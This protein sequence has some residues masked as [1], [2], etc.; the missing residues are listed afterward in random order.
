[1]KKLCCL[2]AVFMIFSLLSACG[3][4]RY[5]IYNEADKWYISFS[6]ASYRP[7]SVTGAQVDSAAE[8]KR[9]LLRKTLPE[10]I[11]V[12]LKLQCGSDRLEICDPN[13]MG[14][15]TLPEGLSYEYVTWDGKR[16]VFTIEDGNFSGKITSGDPDNYA[17]YLESQYLDCFDEDFQENYPIVSDTKVEDR[18]ARVVYYDTYLSY[19]KIVLY[20]ITTGETELYIHE[21]YTA[22][23]KPEA[24]PDYTEAN[25]ASEVVPKRVWILGNDGTN[26]WYGWLE[27]FEERPSVEWL[28][29]FGLELI[30]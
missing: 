25:K 10:H 17:Y 15:L 20:Q 12:V 4:T 3:D 21:E 2:L 6:D 26:C 29:A 30:E 22:R 8:L 1:M 28:S 19:N 13:K 11:Y 14:E 27:G 7:M 23:Y 16:F 24:D 18:N 9:M 5:K